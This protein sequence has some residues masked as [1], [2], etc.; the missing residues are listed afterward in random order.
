VLLFLSCQAAKLDE[1]V[2]GGLLNDS[3]GDKRRANAGDSRQDSA[4]AKRRLQ[5]CRHVHAILERQDDRL[6]VD[7]GLE[8]RCRRRRIVRFDAKEH[9]ASW[10]ECVRV[11]TRLDRHR[12]IAINTAHGQAPFLQRLQV[13]A[14]CHERD[15]RT[16]LGQESTEIASQ[17]TAPHHDNSHRLYSSLASHQSSAS[18]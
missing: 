2:C 17:A 16:A 8:E 5:I 10:R 13:V 9:N 7:H 14:A 18:H 15:I 3:R 6:R 12:K 1:T 11:C 4:A